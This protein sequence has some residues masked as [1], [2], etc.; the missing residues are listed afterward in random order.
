[1]AKVAPKNPAIH[2]P[3]ETTASGQ[4]RLTAAVASS[5]SIPEL[6]AMGYTNDE[7][8]AAL[9]ATSGGTAWTPEQQ[10]VATLRSDDEIL[11][12]GPINEQEERRY[13]EISGQNAAAAAIRHRPDDPGGWSP[14]SSSGSGLGD[15]NDLGDSFATGAAGFP[16]PVGGFAGTNGGLQ[17]EDKQAAL[18]ATKGNV[19]VNPNIVDF[20][21]V[22]VYLKDANGNVIGSNPAAQVDW[23]NFPPWQT[24]RQAQDSGTVAKTGPGGSRAATNAAG[25]GGSGGALPPSSGGAAKGGWNP[26]GNSGSSMQGATGTGPGLGSMQTATDA[27]AAQ[28]NANVGAAW[29]GYNNYVDQNA[30]ILQSQRDNAFNAN[31]QDQAALQ[32]YTGALN[33][34][35]AFLDQNLGTLQQRYGTYSQL[36]PSASSQWQ[37]DLTSQAASAQADPQAIAAQYQALGQ[38]QGAAGGSLNTTSQAAQAYADPQAVALQMRGINDLYGASKGSLDVELNPEMWG[39]QLEAL[40]QYDAWRTPELTDQERFMK[41]LARVE[42]EQGEKASRDAVYRNQSD[43][44]MG[45]S[46]LELAN[47]QMQSQQNSTNRMLRDLGANANAVSRAERSLQGYANLGTDMQGQYLANEHGNQAVQ[48]QALGLYTDAAGNLRSQSFDE[49][50]K[51]GMAGDQTAMANADRQLQAMGMSADTAGNIRQ[52]SFSEDYSRGMAA[53]NMS[54]YNRT[55]SLAASQWADGYRADQQNQAWG[56]DT[57]M[58][59]AGM[60]TNQAKTTN[61]GNQFGASTSVNDTAYGRNKDTTSAWNQINN[62]NWQAGNQVLDRSDAATQTGLG[63]Q[64]LMYGAGADA[65]KRAAADKAAQEAIAA[66]GRGF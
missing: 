18:A 54:Q 61:A 47:M 30:G 33:D 22:P 9:Q 59:G 44:G 39:R 10:A 24:I 64:W 52:Q 20:N 17:A 8:T 32:T 12:T 6:Q 16:I 23:N 7:I 50:F 36:A 37:G 15:V 42:Q 58:F 41:E 60:S 57:D 55:T 19:P 21:G 53:D 29:G 49:A 27:A 26:L 25:S 48:L 5:H 45:G 4:P 40:D 46:G 65:D 3:G 34:S 31:L 56:R 66:I 35:N 13:K 1:M 14:G 63:N 43:R 62:Q 28:R 51:R 11:T 38:M 2:L